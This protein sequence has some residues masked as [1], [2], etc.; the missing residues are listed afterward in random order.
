M[1]LVSVGCVL[2]GVGGQRLRFYL[3]A[4]LASEKRAR[5]VDQGYGVH[6]IRYIVVLLAVL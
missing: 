4:G 5:V 3:G 6:G 2:R 1:N